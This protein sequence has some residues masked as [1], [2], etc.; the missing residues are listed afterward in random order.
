M[1]ALPLLA[2]LGWW[3]FHQRQLPTYDPAYREY[4]YISNGKSNT[5][6]VLDLTPRPYPRF[7]V[8]KTIPVGTSPTG[9]AVNRKKNEIYVVNSDSNN[10]SVID[11][12]R[13][14]VVATIG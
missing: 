11:A 1:I 10:V 12:E 3:Y 8:L 5:V 4:A 13:N 14:V 6:S 9:L 7:N 2:G